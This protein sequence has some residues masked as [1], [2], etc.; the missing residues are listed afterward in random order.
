[1]NGMTGAGH[2]SV[3]QV[4]LRVNVAAALLDANA[5]TGTAIGQLQQHYGVS[6]RQARRYIEQAQKLG[7]RDIPPAKVAL[8][9]KVP[10]DLVDRV[11]QYAV[12]SGQSV[13]ATVSQALRQFLDHVAVEARPP[14]LGGRHR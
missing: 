10:S 12:Q 14:D 6:A 8:T 1:M 3:G 13:S 9:V 4:T 11:R 5:D 7:V 2:G